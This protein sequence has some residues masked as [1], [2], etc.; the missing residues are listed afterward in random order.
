[1]IAGLTRAQGLAALDLGWP[2][3]QLR[4][5]S[6]ILRERGVS[7]GRIA[8]HAIEVLAPQRVALLREEPPRLLETLLDRPPEDDAPLVVYTDG[9]GTYNNAPC[10]AGVVVYRGGALIAERSEQAGTGTNNTAELHAVRVA[11]G[12]VRRLDREVLIRT[13]SLYV[14]NMVSAGSA[15]P[16]RANA[17]LV[18]RLRIE[19]SWRPR[20]RFEHVRGHQRVTPEHTADQAAAIEGNQRADRLAGAAR[21][22]AL[23]LPEPE[24]KK[25]REQKAVKQAKKPRGAWAV[26]AA[27]QPVTG[28]RT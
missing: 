18:H 3:P 12:L 17:T 28:G 4:S 24:P 8:Y 22:A 19:S 9:S 25:P 6:T 27:V 5:I 2:E 21:R 7:A 1:M 16:A 11:L 20:L 14:I 23:G 26:L 13:D 10:G 15:Y